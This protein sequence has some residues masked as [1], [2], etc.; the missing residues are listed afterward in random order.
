ME[1]SLSEMKS[2]DEEERAS[3]RHKLASNYG[4]TGLSILYRLFH[5]YN[6]DVLHD[7]IFDSMHTLLLRIVKRHLE[8]YANNGYLSNHTVERRLQAM[9]WTA[10][11]CSINVN[12]VLIY[13]S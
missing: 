12:L 8:Y 7:L 2:V 3:V 4:F 10:G 5:L 13:A 6:F 1:E 11:C 9:P